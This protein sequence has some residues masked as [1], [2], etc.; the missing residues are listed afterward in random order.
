MAQRLRVRHVGAVLA[1]LG[2]LSLA[3][4]ASNTPIDDFSGVPL[5]PVQ[6]TAEEVDVEDEGD[7][8][9]VEAEAEPEVELEEL[10]VPEGETTAAYLNYGDRLAIVLWGSSTCPPVGSQ[11]V[12]TE[13]AENGNAVRVDLV[14]RPDDE[15]CTMDLVPHTTVFGTPQSI[16]TT[17][18]LRID[19]AGEEIE[20]AVK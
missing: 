20:L 5:V 1:V 14:E 4:C 13:N 17:L 16:T 6:A 12:V 11:I 7:V 8:E 9:E 19:V 10:D 2:A 3:G 18:P 15:V